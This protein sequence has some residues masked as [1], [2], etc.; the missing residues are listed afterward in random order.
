MNPEAISP[1]VPVR[2]LG[3]ALLLLLAAGSAY[4]QIP[5]LLRNPKA[6]DGTA[7]WET[8]GLA[9]VEQ[10]K[11]G[12]SHFVVRNRGYFSQD[13]R[14]PDKSTGK[15]VLLIGRLASD[16][17]NPDKSSTGLPYLYGYLLSLA[18]TKGGLI[19]SFLQS[20]TMFCSAT[21][22]NEWVTAWG[23]FKIPAGAGT[24]RFLLMQAEKAGVPQN[25]SA[26]RFDDL[27]LFIFGTQE[28]AR[29]FVKAF[30]Q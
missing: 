4:G 13:V 14:L 27:G 20:D 30:H 5:N 9:T 8:Y 24:V 2:Y 11:D 22:E 29:A 17:I 10:S 15:F 6:E 19:N 12:N 28:E 23:I 18:N 26:A 7:N 3:V 1:P 21:R 16:R 25:G